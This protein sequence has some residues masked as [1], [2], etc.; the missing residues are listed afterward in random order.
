MTGCWSPYHRHTMRQVTGNSVQ[1]K[2]QLKPNT[3]PLH[4]TAKAGTT[5]VTITQM[6][7]RE[8]WT[9]EQDTQDRSTDR[10]S[11]LRHATMATYSDVSNLAMP[12][13]KTAKGLLRSYVVVWPNIEAPHTHFDSLMK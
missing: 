9:I 12:K 8:T 10:E 11:M 5:R 13:P 1:I 4:L 6:T 2:R 3:R 7:C